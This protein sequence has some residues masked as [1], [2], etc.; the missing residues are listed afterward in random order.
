MKKLFLT[1]ILLAFVA[2]SI[3]AKKHYTVVLS[4]DGYRWDYTQWY[5]T[6]FMDMMA[7]KGVESG[8][9]PSYPSKTF[10]NHYTLA[11]GLYPDH[12]GIVANNFYDG[13]ILFRQCRTEN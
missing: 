9:I 4:L 1:T 2:I 10:P 6:P 11:T 8:L 13:I 12:H 7:E 5:N 3:S